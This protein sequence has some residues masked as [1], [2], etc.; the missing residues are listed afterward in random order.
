MPPSPVAAAVCGN[1][2]ERE[3]RKLSFGGGEYLRLHRPWSRLCVD[4]NAIGVVLGSDDLLAFV[5][6][7]HGHRPW[8]GNT[9]AA[10]H[11]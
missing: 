11:C 8:I 7:G 9:T 5:K 6:R 1:Y 4:R 10:Y 3:G 2:V